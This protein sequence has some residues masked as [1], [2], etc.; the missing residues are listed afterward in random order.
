[1]EKF[2]NSD[3][4]YE[5]WVR[6]NKKKKSSQQFE[7]GKK[8]YL[9]GL[10]GRVQNNLSGF[11][12]V[13]VTALIVFL[14]VLLITFL[15][16]LLRQFT[17]YFYFIVEIISVI[18]IVTLVNRNQSPSYRLAWISIVLLL[19]ISGFFMYYLWGRSGKKRKYLDLYILRQI[20][21]G[22]KF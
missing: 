12:R 14:Q 4:A 21:Y 18:A 19:P 11:L 10:K 7:I 5:K 8:K 3:S 13:L 1:M 15:P 17:V 9:K 22:N 6:K 2:F 20:S 16:F